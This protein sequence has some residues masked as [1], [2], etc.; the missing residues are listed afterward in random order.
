MDATFSQERRKK[1]EGG[2]EGPLL[3][4]FI[5]GRKKTF[6]LQT[7]FKERRT[8]RDL[9]ALSSLASKIESTISASTELDTF[10]IYI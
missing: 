5:A 8:Q 9:K 7:P 4:L 2:V 3:P 1:K 6:L 10:S